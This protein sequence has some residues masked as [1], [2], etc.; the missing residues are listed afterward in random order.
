MK[1]VGETT[2]EKMIIEKFMR[3]LTHHFDHVIVAI[4]ESGNFH[5]RQ[6]NDLVGTLEADKL[7]IIED[8]DDDDDDDD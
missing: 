8:D 1:S 6:I 7:R 2:T 5:T 4:Q 3:T